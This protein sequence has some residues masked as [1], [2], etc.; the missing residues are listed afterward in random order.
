MLLGSGRYY[1]LPKGKLGGSRRDGRNLIEDMKGYGY[2]YVD[3]VDEFYAVKDIS[4][5]T[6]LLGSFG[7]IWTIEYVLDCDDDLQHS[8]SLPEMAA[9]AIE[10]LSKYPGGFFLMIEG[11]AIDWMG[12][13]RD[14][15]GVVAE[16][17]EFDAA[18]QLAL[19]FAEKDGN[20]LVVVTADHET[21]DLDSDGIDLD[22]VNGITATTEFMRGL[23]HKGH[24]PIAE[25]METY[26]GIEDL[27]A[28]ELWMIQEYGEGRISDVLSAR[29]GVSWGWNGSD[30]GNHTKR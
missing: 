11:G 16:T 9:K 15:A 17:L 28:L 4:G 25:V 12:H 22:F 14:I 18:I 10:V 29:A 21:G 2:H 5:Y 26:A 27:T 1:M 20:T 19:D 6:G 3:T 23:I 24:M 8:P 13:N 30:N 7:S